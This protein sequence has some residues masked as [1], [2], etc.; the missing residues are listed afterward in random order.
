MNVVVPGTVVGEDERVDTVSGSTP[1]IHTRGARRATVSVNAFG[2]GA[3]EWVTNAILGLTLPPVRDVVDAAGLTI[4]AV[5][6]P[7]DLSRVLDTAF[8]E[9]MLYEFEVQY[10]LESAPVDAIEAVTADFDYTADG[11]GPAGVLN[12]TLTL[13]MT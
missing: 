13:D 3:I 8:E 10:G 6:G 4:D 9:R 5:G 12:T 7:T 1:Q 2:A 11:G